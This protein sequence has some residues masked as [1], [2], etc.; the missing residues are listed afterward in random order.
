MLFEENSNSPNSSTQSSN[1]PQETPVLHSKILSEIDGIAEKLSEQN[2][3]PSAKK[4]DSA[5]SLETAKPAAISVTPVVSTISEATIPVS[6]EDQVVPSLSPK[7]SEFATET[8]ATVDANDKPAPENDSNST[9]LTDKTETSKLD[10]DSAVPDVFEK[11]AFEVDPYD[12][13]KTD[14]TNT[15]DSPKKTEPD[16][17]K[18][19]QDQTTTDFSDI[20]EPSS[21]FKSLKEDVEEPSVNMIESVESSEIVSAEVADM[22]QSEQLVESDEGSEE[23]EIIEDGDD[24]DYADEEEETEQEE[25]VY[26]EREPA[27][28]HQ[29]SNIDDDGISV[30]SENPA[31]VEPRAL[32]LLEEIWESVFNPGVNSRVQLVFNMIFVGLFVL[33]GYMIY[34]TGGSIHFVVLLLVAFA[35]FISVQWFLSEYAKIEAE[36]QAILQAEQDE[37]YGSEEDVQAEN[38][39]VIEQEK[40]PDLKKND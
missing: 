15:S 29:T 16:V 1:T 3:L 9:P 39:D 12:E 25:V 21:E 37:I 13:I 4:E 38:E 5:I 31:P 28:V 6:K 24:M 33:L 17:V 40:E 11:L 18:A 22:S 32:S 26:I 7:I 30:T 23:Y 27:T 36:K 10:Q 14:Q 19:A 20:A 35:L 34:F 2:A 8:E